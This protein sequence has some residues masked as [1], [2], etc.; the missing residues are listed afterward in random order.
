MSRW[1]HAGADPLTARY[2]ST[3]VSDSARAMT[4]GFNALSTMH[5]II[6]QTQR[7]APAVVS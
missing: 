2:A 1:M 3:D 7:C 6:G 4:G 5:D